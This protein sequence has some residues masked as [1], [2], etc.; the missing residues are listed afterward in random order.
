VCATRGSCLNVHMKVQAWRLRIGW[1]RSP[2]ERSLAGYVASCG[3]DGRRG[4]RPGSR[5]GSLDEKDVE[6]HDGTE[7]R[8]GPM[9]PRTYDSTF[10]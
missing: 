6:R 10:V 1:H 9:Q 5:E 8:D 3:R 7:D 4:R 2:V